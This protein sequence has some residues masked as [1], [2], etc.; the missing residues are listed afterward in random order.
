M[1]SVAAMTLKM[2]RLVEMKRKLWR[3]CAKHLQPKWHIV[4][5]LLF[6]SL[7][8]GNLLHVCAVR[9]FYFPIHQL[10]EKCTVHNCFKF[11]KDFMHRKLEAYLMNILGIVSC[12]MHAFLLRHETT[13]RM[14][15]QVLYYKQAKLV[16]YTG[17]SHT[18]N[19]PCYLLKR[20]T[21]VW[22][23]P[24]N[25]PECSVWFVSA[26]CELFGRTSAE[27]WKNL[28]SLLQLLVCDILC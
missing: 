5:T 1:K 11:D 27:L 28:A 22:W 24:K 17:D 20:W 7:L 13:P 14:F 10:C 12:I 2:W 25:S 18:N 9:S 21:E 26:T 6:C 4:F 19:W 15:M 16:A 3:N 23:T 8:A